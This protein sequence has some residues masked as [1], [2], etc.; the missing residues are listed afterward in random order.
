[1][2]EKYYYPRQ[3][4]Y[5]NS[6]VSTFTS[7]RHKKN[8]IFPFLFILVVGIGIFLTA[9]FLYQR[10]FSSSETKN[11]FHI[12]SPLVEPVQK[13]I[14][15]INTFF[16]HDLEILVKD[17][18]TENPG[19]Y[20]IAIKNL[21]S[22]ETY[23]Y[24][25]H[26]EYYS[27]SLYKLWVMGTVYEQV[28]TGVLGIEDRVKGSVED[29][30]KQFGIA[31]EEAEL[32]TGD[33]D[34]SVKSALEQMIT[35]S[36]NYSA[37]LLTRKVKLA[38]VNKFLTEYSLEDSK[39]G[40]PPITTAFDLAFFYEQLYKGN[41][42]S[43]EYSQVMLDTLKRQQLNDRIPKYL[44]E[45][46]K[47]AH[48]TG[49]LY[50]YKHDAGIVFTPQGDYVIVILSNTKFPKNAAENEAVLSERVYNYFVNKK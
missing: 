3:H 16:D 14:H 31:S 36:H 41:I 46:V 20:A 43:K 12:L 39:T 10:I 28:D 29:L 18:L 19:D 32:T 37:L 48:K 7:R 47:V 30:N 33:F 4:D 1:M 13:S 15:V 42:V 34:L 27:A 38:S 50:G 9:G 17:W 6:G 21:K 23:Y 24:N 8:K 11:E 40:S 44:P 22:G 5:L 35:I 26:K 2:G 49:E 25:P 45:N